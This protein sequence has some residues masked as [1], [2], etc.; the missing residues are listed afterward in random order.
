MKRIEVKLSL[1]V[2]APLLDVMKELADHLKEGLAAPQVLPDLD[3]EFLQAWTT[4]LLDSQAADVQVLLALF[5]EE[6]FSEGVIGL[7]E[8][9]AEPVV[10][11]CAAVRLR[12]REKFLKDI[13][14]E[15]LES[16]DVDIAQLEERVRKAFMCYL[17]LATLQELIIQHL[18]SSIIES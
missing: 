5:N 1:P 6:F 4:D 9:N 2:V 8:S 15:T 18:D 16:S 13:G 14:D 10:R 17:F 3:A 11:A 12:L 7:D